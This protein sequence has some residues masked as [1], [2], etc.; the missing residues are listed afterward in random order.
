MDTRISARERY[1]RGRTLRQNKMYKQAITD[2][3]E[4]IE[5]PNY[6][7]QAYTQTALCLRALGRHEEA[8]MALR[9]ALNASSLSSNEAMHVLYLLGQSLESLGRCAEAIEAYNCVR[10]EDAGFLDV[11]S[12]IKNLCGA[13]RSLWSRPLRSS[14]LL[15]LGRT[16]IDRFRDRC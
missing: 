14:D 5:D 12:R 3:R 8:V 1:E 9:H 7:G 6:R 15:H 13:R 4:A 10:Q 11:D 16:L 2:L